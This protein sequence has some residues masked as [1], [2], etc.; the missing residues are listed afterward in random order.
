MCKVPGKYEVSEEGTEM[1][2]DDREMVDSGIGRNICRTDSHGKN[3]QLEISSSNGLITS[4]FSTEIIQ[5]HQ[6]KHIIPS[7]K[8]NEGKCEK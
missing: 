1:T 2:D 3:W 5:T 6:V 8:E 7:R 4:N